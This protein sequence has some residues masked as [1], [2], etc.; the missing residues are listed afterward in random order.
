[1]LTNEVLCPVP[2]CETTD[3]CRAETIIFH[4]DASKFWLVFNLI[5][6]VMFGRVRHNGAAML[7]RQNDH[8]IIGRTMRY[9]GIEYCTMAGAYV[10]ANQLTVVSIY[11]GDKET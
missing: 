2:F 8:N 9:R 11:H 5:L 6:Q 1:M 10:G 7:F 3:I 4:V